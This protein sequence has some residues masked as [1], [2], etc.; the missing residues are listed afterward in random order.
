MHCGV[1][2]ELI[3]SH[4]AGGIELGHQ[5]TSM[6][7]IWWEGSCLT[8][9]SSMVFQ[10]SPEV[11]EACNMVA[12]RPWFHWKLVWSKYHWFVKKLWDSGVFYPVSV[13]FGR[14]KPGEVSLEKD[15]I[16]PYVPNVEVC[17]ANCLE[18]NRMH[19]TTLLFFRGRTK[20]NAVCDWTLLCSVMESSHQS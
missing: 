11:H 20:R 2:D 3:I 7:K 6:A 8:C 19:R 12:S 9:S 1:F 10:I 4:S 13:G 18:Y 15:V 14:Y 16:L 5:P 17:D